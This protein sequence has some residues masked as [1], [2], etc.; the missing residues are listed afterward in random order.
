MLYFSSYVVFGTKFIC[1]DNE[2]IAKGSYNLCDNYLNSLAREKR[3]VDAGIKG[4]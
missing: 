1:A 3:A 4:F 2:I